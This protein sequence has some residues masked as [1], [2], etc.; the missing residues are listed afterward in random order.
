MLGASGESLVLSK[1]LLNGFIAGKAPEFTKDFDLIVVSEDGKHSA[2]IQV[3]T[4]TYTHQWL[5]NKKHEQ[6]IENLIFCFVWISKDKNE[7]KIFLLDSQTVAHALRVSHKIWE[8]IPGLKKVKNKA[9]G[10]RVLLTDYNKLSGLPTTLKALQKEGKYLS[11][12]LSEEDMRFLSEHSQGWLE[13]YE[14]DWTII[15]RYSEATIK[16]YS[17]PTKEV[18]GRDRQIIQEALSIAIPIILRNSLSSSNTMDMI[19]I[20]LSVLQER[21]WIKYPDSAIQEFIDTVIEDLKSGKT[22]ELEKNE[23]DGIEK[24]HFETAVEQYLKYIVPYMKS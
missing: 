21:G 15:K 6:F 13:K 24:S 22:F 9:T 14:N 19:R 23:R 10:M 18:T 2:P 3:K 7:E 11:E 8:K 17:E 1:L 12:Y 5:M 20:L 16:K 4:T